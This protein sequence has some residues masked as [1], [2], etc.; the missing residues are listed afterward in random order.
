VGML[1]WRIVGLKVR[2][3]SEGLQQIAAT[4]WTNTELAS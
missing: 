3:C 1:L 2:H 4:S